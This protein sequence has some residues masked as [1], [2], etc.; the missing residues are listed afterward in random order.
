MSYGIDIEYLLLLS[1]GSLGAVGCIAALLTALSP[2]LFK[3]G[4]LLLKNDKVMDIAE[5]WLVCL[6]LVDTV[7]QALSAK[8]TENWYCLTKMHGLLGYS[9]CNGPEAAE[10]SGKVPLLLSGLLLTLLI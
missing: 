9:Y 2:E 10:E 8:I 5:Y 4:N 6:L 1:L 7:Y 3:T